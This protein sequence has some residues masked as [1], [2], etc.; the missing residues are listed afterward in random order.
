M[1]Q[2]TPMM[3]QYIEIKEQCKDCIL[4]FRLGDFYEMFFE[5]AVTVSKEL[6]LCLTGRDCGLDERAPM[7][8]IPYH[9][10]DSY[11]SRLIDKGYKVAICEQ[12][13]DPSLAK[14]IVKRDIIRIVTPG[15]ITDLNLLDEKRN[16]YIMSIYKKGNLYG[17][18]YCDV[19]TGEFHASEFN[20]L[21]IQGIVDEVARLFPSE[22]IFNS[23]FSMEHKQLLNKFGIS[24]SPYRDNCFEYSSCAAKVKEQFSN[25]SVT[26]SSIGLICASGALL[27]YIEE[28][29][30]T[31]LSHISKL[32]TYSSEDFMMLDTS[33]R[34]NLELTETLRNKS[35]KGSLLWVLDKTETAMGSRTLRRWIEEPL[36]TS[37][38]IELRL[39][40][41]EE[42]YNNLYIREVLKENLKKIYDMERLLGKLAYGSINPRDLVS[43]KQSL[44]MI[45]GIKE[46]LEGL[47]S[48]MIRDIKDSIDEL[49]D[50]RELIEESIIDNPPLAVKE[51]GIIKDGYSQEVDRLRRASREGKDWIVGLENQEKEIT[52]IKSL[53]VGYNK[54]FG[55]YIEITKANFNLVPQDR[56]I[57]KQTLANAE[58]Y[59]TPELKEME[60]T[61]LGAEEKVVELE[62][63]LFSGIRE[64]ISRHMERIQRTSLAVAK[65]DVL[66]SLAAVASQN[67]Y[68]KPEI[69]MEGIIDIKDG[70]HP[71]VEKMLPD[72]MF[73]PNDIYL[74]AHDN[75]VSI[76]TGP[77]MAGKST[78]M[79]QAALLVIM[80]Q[81]GSFIPASNGSI[82]IVDR[83][84][85]RIGASDDL[86]GGQSTFMVEMSEVANILNNSTSR[87]L[88]LL[89]E[90]GRGTSTYDGLSIAWAVI[91]YIS[92]KQ[93]VGAKTLFAT[94]YHELTELEGKIQGIKNYCISVKE[95][96]DDIIFLRKIIRGG[97]DRSYGIQVAKLA[98]LPDKI[99]KRA[100]EIIKMLEES[101]I[102]KQNL[103]SSILH[104]KEVAVDRVKDDWEQLSFMNYGEHS[105]I[106]EIKNVDILNITPMEA[107]VLLDNFI[108]KAR[109]MN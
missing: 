98:G 37:E 66:C 96:G 15:T 99:I 6:E 77:N 47:S 107:M 65:V 75:R 62:Y 100:H 105:I 103:N 79:R 63:Q 68:I 12:M 21:G 97:A 14:G 11:I 101:D 25:S 102:I 92:D 8:G 57:R 19:S 45:P 39:N 1:A 78:Y 60:S 87:S 54:V 109:S 46:A 93:V 36:V 82:G 95:H 94:H 51:G 83:V 2:L 88:I 104:N 23:D 48:H 13:E 86:A 89:D 33:T 10:A 59:I 4:F 56:Y 22:I 67:D 84:F 32:H 18:A 30:K 24:L 72:R 61:I 73:V 27:Y 41:V 74:D 108:K 106:N 9:A 64:A 7:C 80:A 53:K 5:D 91:E 42:L 40:A 58:R 52:G 17:L 3:Q 76:I 55:Y 69:N 20:L 16:N 26:V 38:K 43:L 28:T 90:V 70:R 81:I 35:R 85:T 34:R 50:V 29:Q 44:H 49:R 71:V 31:S